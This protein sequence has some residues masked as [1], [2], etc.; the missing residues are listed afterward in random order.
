MRLTLTL[1][2]E[3]IDTKE[4]P[5]HILYKHMENLEFQMLL[6]NKY[7]TI[8]NNIHICFPTKIKKATD[9]DADIDS[10]L[11]TINIFCVRLIKKISVA[12]YGNDNQLIP[13]SSP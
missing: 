6:T 9:E 10:D 5:A 3:D 4:Q 2:L 12:K 1:T 8:P 11:I 7:Y 13:T